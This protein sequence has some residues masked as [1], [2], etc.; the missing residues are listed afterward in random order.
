MQFWF[1]TDVKSLVMQILLK[2][3]KK[4]KLAEITNSSTSVKKNAQK[5]KPAVDVY[6]ILFSMC[7]SDFVYMRSITIVAV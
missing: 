7:K 4:K 3:I 1:K 2:H 5:S 6:V